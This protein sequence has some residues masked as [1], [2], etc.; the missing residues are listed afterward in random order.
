MFK[1][2]IRFYSA[3]IVLATIL[4]ACE[5]AAPA[6]TTAPTLEPWR[7]CAAEGADAVLSALKTPSF[8]TINFLSEGEYT[9]RH[10]TETTCPNSLKLFTKTF[11][12]LEWSVGE[13]TIDA[14][15]LISIEV[16]LTYA[17]YES[18]VDVVFSDPEKMAEIHRPIVLHSI[19]LMERQESEDEYLTR[20]SDYIM[21]EMDKNPK[22]VTTKGTLVLRYNETGSTWALVSVPDIFRTFEWFYGQV[23]PMS[24]QTSTDST[25]SDAY[26]IAATELLFEEKEIEYGDYYWLYDTFC[27][28]AV[29]KIE[30]VKDRLS[31]SGWA[32]FESQE[33]VSYYKTG[34]PQFAFYVDFFIPLP[35]LMLFYKYYKVGQKA[36]LM[37]DKVVMTGLT[38]T[39][40]TYWPEGGLK[41]GEYKI[42]VTTVDG[43][44]IVE[45]TIKVK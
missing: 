10:F 17:D 31:S 20:Y 42:I 35:G 16:E 12:A 41:K 18:A 38:G 6:E 39:Y 43:S 11:G 34:T 24:G 1:K 28:R 40:L 5:P 32:D 36:P 26:M 44:V 8:E 14:D 15:S 2:N 21:A 3:I 33:D 30:E 45:D 23:D 29:M 7:V 22:T 27:S 25:L 37:E 9:I 4:S 19:N 13:A